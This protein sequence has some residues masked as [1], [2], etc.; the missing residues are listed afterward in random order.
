MSEVTVGEVV[1]VESLVA[2]VA[3]EFR[4]RQA[5]GE[6]P[7]PEEYARRHPEAAELLRKVLASLEVLGLSLA[8]DEPGASATGEGPTGTLGDFLLIREVGRGG[9]GIVYE[10]EQVSLGRRVALK[11]LPFA[12]T[13]DP[14]QLQRFHN[15][16]RAA[17]GLHHTNIVPV[18]G[19][20]N[21]RGV[22][23]YAMQF[24]EGRTLADVIAQQRDGALAQVPT[25]AGAE[26]AATTIPPA[27][28]ATSA[29]PRD[30]AY[31]RRV[32]EW[33][34]QAAEALDCAHSLGVVHRD[35]KPANL[36]VD[37]GGRLW[38][39]DFGLAQVQS[40]ARLTMTGDL[41]GTLR[42]MSPEQALAKRVVID[43]RTDVYSLAATLYELLALRPAF[44]GA[45]RQELLR[46]IAFEEPRTPRRVNKAIPEELQTIVLKA[47]E[48]NP[49]ERYAT[50]QEMAG[51]LRRFL[52]HRPIEAKPSSLAKKLRKW[53]Q[54]HKAVVTTAVGFLIV[55][56][57][58]LA[59]STA[60]I[61]RQQQQTERA[62]EAEAEQRQ[63]ADLE[64]Q[65]AIDSLKD[66]RAAVEQM[67]TRVGAKELADVPQMESTRRE[68]LTD[69][70]R[71]CRRFLERRTSDP[72]LQFEAARVHR[73]TGFIQLQLGEQSQ[74]EQNFQE[75]IRLLQEVI[76]GRG[77]RPEDEEELARNYVNL[78]VVREA[79]GQVADAETA[80]QDAVAI[81]SRL[82]ADDARSLVHRETLGKAY[83]NL[84]FVH[85]KLGRVQQ[86]DDTFCQVIG[87]REQV[88]AEFPDNP[89]YRNDL[90]SSYLNLAV[91]QHMTG[92][93]A[94]AEKTLEKAVALQARVVNEAPASGDY[95]RTL[96]SMYGQ[97][98]QLLRDRGQLAAADDVLGESLGLWAN[99]VRDFPHIPEYRQRL[100]ELHELV[101]ALRVMRHH[102]REAVEHF[103]QACTCA[104]KLAELFPQKVEYRQ[105]LADGCHLL[106]RLLAD[107]GDPQVRNPAR[108][109]TEA[110]KAVDLSPAD[111][112]YWTALGLA[113]YRAGQWQSAVAALD[114]ATQ[115]RPEGDAAD[116]FF[117]A[118]AH[119]QMGDKGDAHQWY[120]RAVRWTE[121]TGPRHDL[122]IYRK[123]AATVLGIQ[124][125]PTP[126]AKEETPE[127]D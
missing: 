29:V 69:A 59:V 94:A 113:R 33:G 79:K 107:S 50:A 60:L 116:F 28:H 30:A 37:G 42:Y 106:A 31:Y 83:A 121:R 90:A 32:A 16:A 9:M 68:L 108:A 93:R 109:V 80:Y 102:D 61:W 110:K 54:R 27:A 14:R 126:K 48:K 11:V 58:T 71:F 70:L 8:S 25:V 40:D 63:Q 84:G 45:D 13:M 36:L 114:R 92:R 91:F 1:S 97:L 122:G 120:D 24:I 81:E 26:A 53:A 115:L 7:D 12:A 124:E 73:L 87:L 49:Q 78:A 77:A 64:R 72:E 66:A 86:A 95:R 15:E 127:K 118:M 2:R 5:R 123:E 3:D 88:A 20:G 85:G 44:D 103:D 35:V 47:M 112:R 76:A 17:A 67:L 75:A 6:R 57:L 23:Y 34:I 38:V 100:G 101:G 55:V 51:D 43:H 52:E 89:K 125:L 98:G 104:G 10:A 111:A 18:Y 56:A 21:E 105:H 41:V 19:V 99:L 22:H 96:A 74:A 119:A 82:L 39:T 65:R 62:Y 46:Q 4:E 117:L